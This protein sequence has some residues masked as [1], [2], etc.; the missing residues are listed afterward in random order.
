M[1]V[2]HKILCLVL[3]LAVGAE[4]VPSSV[5]GGVVVNR[6]PLNGVELTE[7]LLADAVW[8]GAEPLPGEWREEGRVASL[9][10]MHLMARPKLFGREV[11]LLRAQ[12]RE[13]ALEALEATFVDAGSYFGYFQEKLP[14]GLNRR[15]KEEEIQRRMARRQQEFTELYSENLSELRQSLTA[16]TGD[17]KSKRVKIGQTR[18]LRAEPEE[19]RMGKLTLRLLAA[20]NRLLRLSIQPT[21]L[22]H[23]DW[24]DRSLAGVKPRERLASIASKVERQEDGTVII[25]DLLPIPQGFQP[26]CGLNTLAMVARHLGMHLD[27]DWLAA[28]GGFQNTGSAQGSNM[29]RLYQAVA[30]EA[31][32]NMERKSSLDLARLRSSVE[33]GL[34]VIVWRRFSHERN[35][36]H[37]RFLREYRKDPSKTL[38]DPNAPAEQAGWPGDSAPLHAS[39]IVGY[40]A[41]RGEILFL[42][43][44]TGRDVPRRMRAEE[45]AATTYLSFAFK[46]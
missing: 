36:L 42:E 31:G 21:E 46:P 35:E 18:A 29:L 22:A 12:Q 14:E 25:R 8:A 10:I 24:M 15:E 7:Q 45:L 39:V 16:V 2:G 40:H 37:D 30:S 9:E 34:P 44:W 26:Y 3:A 23:Q 4:A 11:L 27:E 20:E 28:A 32:I 5:F 17:A 13:G 41:E 1:K 6:S 33:Q 43:S 19:W 38:P